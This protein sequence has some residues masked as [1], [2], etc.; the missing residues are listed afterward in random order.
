ML[1]D[2]SKSNDDQ[3]AGSEVIFFSI[4]LYL[5][6][7]RRQL[8]SSSNTIDND[9]QVSALKLFEMHFQSFVIFLWSGQLLTFVDYRQIDRITSKSCRETVAFFFVEN[10]NESTTLF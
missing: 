8:F 6:S 3:L 4:D 5:F 9:K 7:S 2:A 10:A 1:I